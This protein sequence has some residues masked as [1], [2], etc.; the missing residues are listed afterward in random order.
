MKRCGGCGE[1]EAE[2][3]RHKVFW[4]NM[5][6]GQIDIVGGKELVSIEFLMK[7][8]LHYLFLEPP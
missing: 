6:G 1:C 2:A 7:A 5:V 3:V 8:N 4:G